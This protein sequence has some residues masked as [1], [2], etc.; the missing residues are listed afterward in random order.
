MG[1]QMNHAIDIRATNY[2]ATEAF[3]I[4]NA[5]DPD[6]LG[7]WGLFGDRTSPRGGTQTPPFSDSMTSSRAPSLAPRAKSFVTEEALLS[8]D[9][10]QALAEIRDS[11]S[12]STVELS[13]IFKVSRQAIYD[14]IEGKNVAFQNR[15]RVAAINEI[16]QQW[17]AF[18]L[19]RMGVL[20]REECNGQSLLELLCADALNQPAATSLINAIAAKLKK[21]QA[22]QTRPSAEEILERHG[23]EPLRG[24]AYRR[25]LKASQ[26]LRH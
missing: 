14:W 21:A 20:V 11:L 2:G 6:R 5:Q 18:E 9:V 3:C 23:M 26:P 19:G 24:Q 7:F 10:P 25:N 8:A 22:A 16:A 15:Q 4:L 12:L 13:K 17:Q 1:R